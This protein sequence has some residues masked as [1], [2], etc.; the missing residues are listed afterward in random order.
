MAG[1][2]TYSEELAAEFWKV[3][4]CAAKFMYTVPVREVFPGNK[5]WDGAVWLFKLSGHPQAKFGYAWL[6][7]NDAGDDLK[8]TIV[9]EITPVDSAQ[10]AVRVSVTG[11]V[12]PW[13]PARAVCRNAS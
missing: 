11:S 6:H 12:E 7:P 10:R 13:K 3:H 1:S 5:I 2:M 8:V 9:L 4:R